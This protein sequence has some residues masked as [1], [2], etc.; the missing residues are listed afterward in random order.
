LQQYIECLWPRRF[1]RIQA[2]IADENVAGCGI[3]TIDSIIVDLNLD[4]PFSRARAPT[5]RKF[6]NLP[7]MSRSRALFSAACLALILIA[8]GCS[9]TD[10]TGG[11]GTTPERRAS[12]FANT[13]RHAEAAGIYI[14][15]ASAAQGV[16]RDRLTLL[17]AAQWLDAG[18]TRRARTAQRSVSTPGAGELL[19]LW[20]ANEAALALRDGK[21]DDALNLLDPLSRLPMRVSERSRVEAL[22]ADAWFQKGDP[23]Q[24]VQLFIQ[25]EAWLDGRRTIELNR[26]RLWAGLL[27]SDPQVLRTAA[28]IS[29]DSQVQGW[30]SLGALATS[31]GRQ[32]IGWS[33]GVIR[34]RDSH[35]GHPAEFLLP[36]F[37]VGD[38]TLAEFP[39]RIALLLP[40]TGSNAAA[41]KAIQNGFF[42]AYFPAATALDDDQQIRVYDVAAAGGVTT[43]YARA[44]EDGAEFVAGPLLRNNVSELA[45]IGLL[46]VPVLALNF[47]PDD[48]MAPPGMFQ[49][50]LAPEDEAAAAA[51]RA[52]GDGLRRA[53]VLYPAND[54]GRRVASSFAG[55]FAS[56]GGTL[57]EHRSYQPSSQDFSMEIES[58][59]ELSQSVRRYQRL[60]ANIGGPL[61]FESRRR[62]DVDCIILAADANSGRLIKS[63]LKFH[64]S[65]DLPVYSTSFIYSMDGKSDADLN[66]IMFA[67]TPW[68]VAPPPWIADYPQIYAEFWPGERR[69]GRLHA[70]GYDA[71]QLIMA[72]FGNRGSSMEEFVGATGRLYLGPDGKIHRRLAW[73]RF[74]RGRPV[75][76]P[77]TE[78]EA[79]PPDVIDPQPSF[80]AESEWVDPTAGQ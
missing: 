70:M 74:E 60:R 44:V 65:G 2:I 77:D 35:L 1:P 5:S 62:Q 42:G 26:R 59:M 7:A 79:A 18:D 48:A 51:S 28:S 69:L 64:Y 8:S 32:G 68:I 50:A 47:L 54:W 13:G 53:V 17:A 15:L 46:P 76:L 36:E 78:T 49:F 22:R 39:R 72:L 40:L 63:Q 45:A 41:G 43:A 71:Y 12:A 16:E 29:D 24:A 11:S 75:A 52:I 66:G 34:W 20:S 55:E 10:S 14:G 30:L 25:R 3:L 80:D 56:G 67:D 58:L 21:P 6:R 61:Q 23:A 19:R 38:G 37:N 57:L 31:T 73:A 33:N 27:V 9:I 4:L